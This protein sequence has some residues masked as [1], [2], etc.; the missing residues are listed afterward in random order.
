[1]SVCVCPHQQWSSKCCQVTVTFTM[2]YVMSCPRPRSFYSP[3]RAPS[4]YPSRGT[5][6]VCLLSYNALRVTP[7]FLHSFFYTWFVFC[8]PLVHVRK[9]VAQVD[10]SL[11]R[12]QLS[13]CFVFIVLLSI[14]KYVI[15]VLFLFCRCLFAVDL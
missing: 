15:C 12:R 1:M 9:V 11:S 5:I 8:K 10:W 7:A 2:F 4:P 3:G 13:S 6:T 14:C